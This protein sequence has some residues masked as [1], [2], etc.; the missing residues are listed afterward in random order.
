MNA[1]ENALHAATDPYALPIEQIDVSHPQL[2]QDDTVGAYFERLRKQAPV[3]YRKNGYSGDFWSI[4]RYRDIVEVDTN[5]EVFSSQTYTGITI[6]DRPP[7]LDR[8]AFI[9]MDPPVHDVQR[10]AVSPVVAPQNLKRLEQGIRE[11]TARILDSLP[12]GEPF[13]WVDQVSIELTT[14]ML[15]TLFDFPFEDRRKLPWW[16]DVAHMDVRSDGPIKSEEQRDDE[17]SKMLA[18]FNQLW[19]ERAKQPPRFDLISM[20]AH[21]PATK[22]LPQNPREF[23]GNLQLLIVGGNDTTR[24]TMSASVWLMSRFAQEMAKLRANPSLIPS[25]VSE[26]IRYQTPLTHM[27]RV[28]KRDVEFKG[29]RIREG[30]RV[31]MWYM[32]GNRD[33]EVIERPEE[34]LIDR[35][36]VRQHL[37]FGFGI[38]RCVGNRLAELQLRIL[39]EEIL[40]RHWTIEVVGDPVRLYSNIIH[41]FTEMKALIKVER[42]K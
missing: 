13:D 18:I 8:P 19:E 36:N 31:I 38:H 42:E 35:P 2:F 41:G 12:I 24:N 32:S 37:S 17:L 15:A 39:W 30:D 7:H 33:D 4:T 1:P 11:R 9:T 14:Q 23:L 27:K 10:K 16:S 5:H 22:D 28:A 20:L 3:H 29:H 26:V 21:D 6:N 40:R 25:M 34:F